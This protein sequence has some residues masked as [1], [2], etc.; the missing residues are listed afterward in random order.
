MFPGE[1]MLQE[2]I[3]AFQAGDRAKA[4]ELLSEV[5][6]IDP[7]NE[8]A[9][10][11]LAASESDPA[12]RKQYLEQVLEINPGNA[13]A[14][15]VLDRIVAREAQSSSQA[16]D[17]ANPPSESTSKGGRKSRI[18]PLDPS[19][20][21]KL[22]EADDPANSIKLPFSIPDAPERVSWENLFRDGVM[23]IRTGFDVLLRKPGVY[24][25]EVSQ[26]TW[27]RFWLIAG[28]AAL[29]SAIMSIFNALFLQIRFSTSLFNIIA[30]LLT[31][32]FGIAIGLVG[33]YVGCYASYRWAVSQGG[34]G[35][36]VKHSYTV[37]IVWAPVLIISSAI[38]LVFNLFGIGV[39]LLTL[40]LSI[41]EFVLIA[42][43]FDRLH[44]FTDP[45]QKWITAVV[46]VVAVILTSIVLGIVFGGLLVAGALPFAL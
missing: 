6:K 37:A 32:F 44:A 12:L 14:R 36:L 35:S 23:L 46:M 21:A 30:V 29:G 2:G 5:V 8:Q 1:D 26:A 3:A 17:T 19:M 28:T 39:G 34:G 9:W 33:L 25:D 10:Y 42:E 38:G 16:A 4:H 11:Y 24:E 22:G 18:R 43:G 15:E 41:Y 45:N 13:K 27:W 7:E 20:G 31:P 40:L